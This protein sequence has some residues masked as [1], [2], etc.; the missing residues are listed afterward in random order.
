MTVERIAM[1]RYWLTKPLA[2]WLK[3]QLPAGYTATDERKTRLAGHDAVEL[4]SHQRN[5]LRGALR[6]RT[7]RVD[8]AWPCPMTQR[9]YRVGV[10]QRRRDAI[11]WPAPLEL[12]C[13]RPVA[14]RASNR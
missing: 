13:C 14:V 7:R 1:S 4:H 11:D 12:D 5:P 6:L 9:I 2:E 3:T 8:L 10:W